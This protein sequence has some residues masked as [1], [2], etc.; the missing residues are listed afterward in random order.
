MGT[1][2]RWGL[3]YPE[4]FDPPEGWLQLKALADGLEAVLGSALEVADTA[5][6][7]ALGTA[8]GVGGR[9]LVVLQVDTSQP[10]M[11]LGASWLA[12]GG[13]GGGGGSSSRGRWRQTGTAQSIPN[14][15]DTVVRLDSDALTTPDITK[16]TSGAGHGFRFERAGVLKGSASVRYATTTAVGVRHAHVVL[17]ENADYLASGGGGDAGQ[18]VPI[19]L[20]IGPVDVAEDDVLSVRC[21]QGTGAPRNLEPNSGAWVH[22]ELELT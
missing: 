5:A 14:S 12:L 6:R 8:I 9:G 11:W 17:G 10:Y 15:A 20:S 2:T 7:T 21:F 18:P 3:V 22:L 13:A 4:R 19:S 1:T 16:I